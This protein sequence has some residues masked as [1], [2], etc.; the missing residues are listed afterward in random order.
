M[1]PVI[2]VF[3]PDRGLW[4]SVRDKQALPGRQDLL[5]AG[6]ETLAGCLE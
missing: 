5:R 6:R 4:G 2:E 3:V 1:I